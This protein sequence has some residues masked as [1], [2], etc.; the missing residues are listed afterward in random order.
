M[1]KQTDGFTLTELMIVIVILGILAAIAIPA[2]IKYINK[3]KTNEAMEKLYLIYRGSIRYFEDSQN[4]VKRGARGGAY[5]GMFPPTEGPTPQ[6]RCCVLSPDRGKCP[7]DPS[8]WE[9][10][11]TWKAL[12]FHISDP[13]YFQYSYISQGVN[14]NASFTARANGDLDCDGVLSTFERA[15]YVDQNLN[16]VGS[17]LIY[18]HLPGE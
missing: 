6:Q 10:S 14:Q 7:P 15:A 8:W 13:F 4:A 11:Q 18:S 16:V 2:F 3:A 1:C 12:D 5:I 17:R 9:D